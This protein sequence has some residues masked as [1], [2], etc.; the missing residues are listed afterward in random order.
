[1]YLEEINAIVE[2]LLHF[3]AENIKIFD[4]SG[5]NSFSQIC[6]IGAAVSDRQLQAFKTELKH[7]EI[8][9][10]F[11]RVHATRGSVIA[12]FRSIITVHFVSKGMRDYYKFDEL[13]IE[14]GAKEIILKH[15]I[16]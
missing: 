14:Y 1:M 5:F 10:F 16:E 15:D 9:S 12:D 6:I 7:A 2:L 8:F 13:W 3:D 4:M 11:P